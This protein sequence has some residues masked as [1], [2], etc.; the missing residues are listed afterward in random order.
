[1]A[2][3]G[4]LASGDPNPQSREAIK[5]RR[6]EQAQERSREEVRSSLRKRLGD[7]FLSGDFSGRTLGNVNVWQDPATADYVVRDRDSGENV[8]VARE[9]LLQRRPG[10]LEVGN[11]NLY[12]EGGLDRYRAEKAAEVRR[13]DSQV[14]AYE[15]AR[16]GYV[17]DIRSGDR[18]VGGTKVVPAK[19]IR[20]AA[21]PVPVEERRRA[22][23]ALGEDV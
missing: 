16:G 9:E 14:M 17:G 4:W 15:A 23:P 13:L 22:A 5:K 18:W 20:K 8:R 2:L 10:R 3:D 11:E 1:M 21:E 12:R 19:P 6:A 7:A